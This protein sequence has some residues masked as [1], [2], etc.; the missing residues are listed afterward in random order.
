MK[1]GLVALCVQELLV[2]VTLLFSHRDA[3]PRVTFHQDLIEGH[4][5][6]IRDSSVD[7]NDVNRVFGMVFS[8]LRDEA[9]VYP[10]ENYYYFVF[11]DRGRQIWG[12]IHFPPAEEIGDYLDFAYWAY[13]SDPKQPAGSDAHYQRYGSAEGVSIKR[14]A[15]LKYSVSY[16]G[17]SVIFSLN[18]VAQKSPEAFPLRR[19][20]VVVEHT[21]DESG[22]KFF[23]IYNEA[24]RHFLFALDESGGLPEN[25]PTDDGIVWIGERSGF[26][27]YQDGGRKILMAVN[28]DNVA[29]NNYFDG[30]FDQLSDNFVAGDSFSRYL[31]EAY[32]YA[33]GRID[34]Y[35]RFTDAVHSRL[36]ITP[37]RF[38]NNLSE[39]PAI[40][41][42]CAGQ[43]LS[44]CITN[45][46]KEAGGY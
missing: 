32:P 44:R 9:K 19:D 46:S 22:Y 29:R 18:N 35:G 4:Y 14:L 3:R 12:N 24:A 10:T 23:L 28:A 37:Y 31:R 27:F 43:E 40:I 13:G 36:A 39:L 5:P 16:R 42:G 20:E 17:K 7:L 34:Q 6:E 38:Y 26:A 33:K 30:P 41:K 45:D 8:A 25:L 11:S 15:P 1:M 21:F 2:L